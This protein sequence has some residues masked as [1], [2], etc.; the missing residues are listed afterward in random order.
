MPSAHLPIERKDLTEQTYRI[1]RDKI[2]KREYKPGEKIV[3]DQIVE[4]F[5]VSRTPVTTA[6]QRLAK[7]RLVE[8]IPQ[9]GTFVIELSARDVSELFDIRLMIELYAAEHILENAKIDRFL[10]SIQPP[11]KGMNQAMVDDEYGD[12]EAFIANDHELH[13]ALVKCT[14]NLRLIDLYEDMNVHIHVARAHYMDSVEKARQAYLEHEMI[15]IGFRA[16]QINSIRLALR[17]HIRTV[18]TRILEILEQ[19]GGAI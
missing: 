3:V 12:Y 7:E 2:L 5:G 18:Q 8:I 17:N 9:R 11:I 19:H 13:L 14:D 10:K 1:L 16:G 4:S 6:L 15:V